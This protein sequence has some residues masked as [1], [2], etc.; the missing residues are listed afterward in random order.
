[1][2]KKS[3]YS[4]AGDKILTQQ[5]L[6]ARD[7]TKTLHKTQFSKIKARIK[8]SRNSVDQGRGGLEGT[9]RPSQLRAGSPPKKKIAKE[10]ISPRERSVA[11]C[12]Q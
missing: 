2:Q 8:L 3:F 6:L 1:M 12:L 7:K 4:I 9:V 5:N 10:K 11:I